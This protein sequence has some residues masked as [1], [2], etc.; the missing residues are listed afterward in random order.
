MNEKLIL[1]NQLI[2]MKL[3]FAVSKDMS[4]V[5]H[6]PEIREAINYTQLKIKILEK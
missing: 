5:E 1:E 6:W 2:I 4:G 3:L